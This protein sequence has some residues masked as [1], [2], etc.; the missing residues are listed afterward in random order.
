MKKNKELWVWLFCILP[1]LV[2]IFVYNHL[3]QQVPMHW[4]LQG[5]I[6]SYGNKLFFMLLIVPMPIFINLIMIVSAKIDPLHANYKKFETT[7]ANF[8]LAMVIFFN[9]LIYA[10]Y[11]VGLGME[12]NMKTFVLVIIGLLFALIGVALRDI[13]RNY[14]FGIRTPWALNNDHN[15]DYTH[16]LGSKVFIISGILLALLGASNFSNQWSF[17]ILILVI[18]CMILIPFIASYKYYKKHLRT[19][20]PGK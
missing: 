17:I 4:N 11:A 8:R 14:F 13:K 7:Y 20:K 19:K 9:L 12:I 3:P 6:D 18:S 2:S 1:I 15:W 10:T 5:E 16:Q